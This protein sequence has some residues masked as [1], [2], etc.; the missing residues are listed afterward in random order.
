MMAAAAVEFSEV[1][2]ADDVAG[3]RVGG[4]GGAGVMWRGKLEAMV[5]ETRA[6]TFQAMEFFVSWQ[7]VLTIAYSGIPPSLL[8]ENP[9]SKWPKT[10]LACLRDNQRLSMEQLQRLH[11]ICSKESVTLASTSEPVIVNK[12]SVVLYAD[13][14][15]EHPMLVTDI[16]LRA[17]VDLSGPSAEQQASVRKVLDVFL[18]HNLNSYYFHA[19]KDGNRS[20]H[21]RDYKGGVTLVHFLSSIPVALAKFK[22]Q[23]EEAMPGMYDWFSEESLHVTLRALL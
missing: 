2:S 18:R 21:Y 10:S 3:G 17:P 4:R 22:E 20:T 5:A 6:A 23:V 15:L 16:P 19:S 8:Q 1:E 7:G 12:L 9:G 11:D 13:C 14:C